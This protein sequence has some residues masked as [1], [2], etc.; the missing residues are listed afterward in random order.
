MESQLPE[1]KRPAEAATAYLKEALDHAKKYIP[2]R[3][4]TAISNTV[5][6]PNVSVRNLS[7][8]L[9]VLGYQIHQEKD[10]YPLNKEFLR[11]L[12][13]Q[14]ALYAV[15]LLYEIDNEFPPGD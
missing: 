12:A 7:C 3:T 13:N 14:A 11:D 15:A 2:E 5:E 1:E 4:A 8:S 6:A 10:A 9:G